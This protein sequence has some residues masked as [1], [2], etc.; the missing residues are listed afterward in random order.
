MNRLQMI[1]V[2]LEE[3]Y[4]EAFSDLGGREVWHGHGCGYPAGFDCD[5]FRTDVEYLV[6]VVEKYKAAGVDQ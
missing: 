1:K 2:R 3:T 4:P 5:C 6:E